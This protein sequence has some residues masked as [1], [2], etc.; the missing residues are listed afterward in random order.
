MSVNSPAGDRPGD[1]AYHPAKLTKHSKE[2]FTVPC[3]RLWV[4]AVLARCQK[5]EQCEKA[6]NISGIY[7]SLP[8][9]VLIWRS[10]RRDRVVPADNDG[11]TEARDADYFSRLTVGFGFCWLRFVISRKRMNHR[12]HGH[13]R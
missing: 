7:R 6:C 9:S 11:Q 4:V 3:G 8:L 5:S 10:Q 13:I 12:R 1:N 2:T